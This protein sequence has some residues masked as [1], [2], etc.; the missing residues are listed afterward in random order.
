MNP[1]PS[2]SDST[3]GS[4]RSSRFGV[5]RPPGLEMPRLADYELLRRI[6]GG[7]YGN[8]WL[9][10]SVLGTWR[11]VKIVERSAFDDDR[12]YEREFDAIRR[13]EP[14]SREHPGHVAILHVGR[15]DE[16]RFFFYV[17]ELAD[18][19]DSDPANPQAASIDAQS[20]VPRTLKTE[21]QRTG[22]M[23]VHDCAQVGVALASALG[24]L[25]EHALVHRDVKP[26]NIIFVRGAPKLA[27]IG[28]VAE[29]EHT[30]SF[31]GT[32]GYVPPEGPGTAQADIYGLGRVLYEMCVGP[33]KH[34]FPNLPTD[35]QTFASDAGFMELNAV[36]MR[37]CEPSADKRYRSAH[38]LASDLSLL[39]SGGSV[40][41]LRRLEKQFAFA[42][43]MGWVAAALVL[44]LGAAWFGA[45]RG[46]QRADAEHARA[47][48]QLRL[49]T[50]H[51]ADSFLRT[52]D[53]GEAITVLAEFARTHSEDAE[54]VNKLL[55]VLHSQPLALP[56]APPM[57]AAG[58]VSSL[59]WSPDETWL[60]A[61][62]AQPPLRVWE[63]STGKVIAELQHA[64]ARLVQF[65]PHGAHLL[66]V[67]AA[68]EARLFDC[69]SW[70]E[71]GSPLIFPEAITCATFSDDGRW[72][73][74]AG[75]HLAGVWSMA[76]LQLAPLPSPPMTLSLDDEVMA[77]TFVHQGALLVT[78]TRSGVVQH[79]NTEQGTPVGEVL[80]HGPDLQLMAM[81]PGEGRLITAGIG[82]V[83]R[84]LDPL[85]PQ[86]RAEMPLP[87][88]SVE[89]LQFGT[90]SDWL[91]AHG[92]GMAFVSHHRA[93]APWRVQTRAGVSIT[94]VHLAPTDGRFLAVES[95]GMMGVHGLGD[96]PRLL[97]RYPHHQRV[98][99]ARFSPHGRRIAT[100]VADGTV[101]IWDA[102]ELTANDMPPTP[103]LPAPTWLCDLAL[104]AAHAKTDGA[105]WDWRQRLAQ[106]PTLDEGWKHWALTLLMPRDERREVTK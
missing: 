46:L 31:V 26:S 49:R 18:P 57:K 13:C 10:R 91:V 55:H 51:D 54:M 48:E 3:R 15:D 72:L 62:C 79:W 101:R 58:A 14:I 40:R 78:A 103:A 67:D 97:A 52:G 86:R 80:E 6:G 88:K 27:D 105:L 56:T 66:T 29:M 47:E 50:L 21:I 59:V 45:R 43:R 63:A 76:E 93:P 33:G 61:A 25:H 19:G 11:A 81:L 84:F 95:D 12:P 42:R 53:S 9:A 106:S 34:Q 104:D 2:P 100:A 41:K 1:A 65:D 92:D 36:I 28:L 22:R 20:Y 98:V 73:A 83:V 17:M 30:M 89:S 75:G 39:L 87:L 70:Q 4:S 68:G 102:S 16:Q 90:I 96:P 69:D 38:E 99:A 35:W 82:G 85:Q 37:A 64:A 8:V 44:L 74:V 77:V 71:A 94:Q 5:E 24:H 32:P 60:T 23:S 7:A